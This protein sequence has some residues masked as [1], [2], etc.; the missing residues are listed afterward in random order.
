[1]KL[2]EL[3]ELSVATDSENYHFERITGVGFYSM[4]VYTTCA[5]P[6]ENRI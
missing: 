4:S 6:H 2:G 5:P 1:M 3:I